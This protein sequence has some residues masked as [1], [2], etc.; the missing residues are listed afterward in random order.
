M[1]K[2]VLKIIDRF[3]NNDNYV[4]ILKVL[5]AYV[6]SFAII[7]YS[8]ITAINLTTLNIITFF[9]FL[10]L[11]LKIKLHID[12]KYNII[13]LIIS[14]IFSAILCIGKYI[15]AYKHNYGVDV[16]KEMINFG[17]LIVFIGFVILLFYLLNILYSKSNG[18]KIITIKE[19]K[20]S[21]RKVFI[22]SFI[23]IFI[24]WLPYFL[25]N[26]PGIVSSDTIGEFGMAAGYE[27]LADHHPVMHALFLGIFYHLGY[28]IF[29]SSTAGVAFSTVAQMI[30]MALIFGYMI[31]FMYNH[32]V[33]K[34]ILI[35][36]L[37][38]FSVFPANAF[39]SITTWK[40]TLFSGAFLLFNIWIYSMYEKKEKIRIID[41]IV[42]IIISLFMIFFRNNAI[43]LYFLCLPFLIILFKYRRKLIIFSLMF[44]VATHYVIKGPVFKYFNIPRTSSA[45]SISI[46]LQQVGLMVSKDVKLNKNEKDMI[47]RVL[48]I[49]IIKK[50]YN[51]EIT[52]SIKFNSKFN[53]GPIN[54]NKFKYLKLWATLVAKHPSMAVEAYLNI[55]LGFW[56]PNLTYSAI[57]G[58]VISTNSMGIKHYNLSPPGF[59]QYTSKIE[60]I[61]RRIPLFN[62]QWNIAMCL[63]II[64]MAMGYCYL[65]N[66]IKS[67]I[68]YIPTVALW[69]TLMIATP[70]FASFR[71]MYGAFISM[72]FLIIIPFLISNKKKI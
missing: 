63:W 45:E 56:Y 6:S 22:L 24:C 10:L 19:Y 47:N 55:T 16:F 17:N 29:N 5:M 68:F 7:L 64:A 3:L 12:K 48:P 66:G 58:E 51:P 21:S 41:Y 43:Y 71:Y 33:N 13:E 50:V 46:P 37:I 52:D 18:I 65:K 53:I 30:M 25:N 36:L 14:F 20:L 9:T 40:D 23:I 34:F 1:K 28:A 49:E 4:I 32:K 69:L 44:V 11:F 42:F 67:I 15:E 2:K 70:T 62:L 8:G 54:Q 60:P 26:F 35:G 57:P 72:P 39:L 31:K 59:K 27:K 61:S 38:F